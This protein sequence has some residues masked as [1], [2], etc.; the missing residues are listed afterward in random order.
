MNVAP[1]VVAP[2]PIP[3]S[4]R[5]RSTGR[6]RCSISTTAGSTCSTPAPARSGASSPMPTTIGEVALAVSD[7]FGV[8]PASIR[9]DVERLID[10][11]R[12]DGLVT[13]DDRLRAVRCRREPATPLG[14]G[15]RRPP[16]GPFPRSTRHWRSSATTARSAVCSTSSCV[17]CSPTGRPPRRSRSPATTTGGRSWSV[18]GSRSS[19]SVPPLGG[20][21]GARRGERRRGA[22][23]ARRSRPPRGRGDRRRG[24]RASAGGV[25]PRQV[26]AH[27]RPRRRRTRVSDR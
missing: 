1:P 11:F 13:V 3:V 22:I 17:R 6:G 19:R 4:S 23:D 25:E 20:A 26:D 8:E 12:A 2:R 9:A 21:T 10:R 18:T 7:R 24:R 5:A 27:D 15:R 16:P 14:R